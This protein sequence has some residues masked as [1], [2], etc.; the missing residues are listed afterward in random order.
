MLSVNLN[1]LLLGPVDQDQDHPGE[2][3]AADRGPDRVHDQ[4]TGTDSVVHDH[5]LRSGE[6]KF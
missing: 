1:I 5:D 4:T 3:D 6:G 2:V